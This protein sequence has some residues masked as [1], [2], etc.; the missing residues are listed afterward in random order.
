M[1]GIN[2]TPEGL[3]HWKHGIHLVQQT[4][5][6]AHWVM[7]SNDHPTH[8]FHPTLGIAYALLHWEGQVPQP[9]SPAITDC[10]FVPAQAILFLPFSFLLLSLTF[11]QTSNYLG[12]SVH[13]C[14]ALAHHDHTQPYSNCI[15]WDHITIK[16][17]YLHAIYMIKCWYQLPFYH[18]NLVVRQFNR[19]PTTPKLFSSSEDESYTMG[20]TLVSS[21]DDSNAMEFTLVL[22]MVWLC[23]G[24][25]FWVVFLTRVIGSLVSDVISF[26]CDLWRW[27][28]C[29]WLT[30]HTGP[31][32]L[33][34][35][36]I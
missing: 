31:L 1:W 4:N 35:L 29:C 5:F 17:D 6:T 2:S 27:N 21:S 24:V 22:E 25:T 8:I 20:F 15:N 13:R 32:P 10:T 9:T 7:H 26:P 30:I 18:S 3:P 14:W 36:M 16:M 19:F 23:W 34:G 28:N 33:S 11:K 12:A